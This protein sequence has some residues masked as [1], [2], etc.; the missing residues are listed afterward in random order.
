MSH[1]L[2]YRQKKYKETHGA[3][4]EVLNRQRQLIKLNSKSEL[5]GR[6]A[7]RAKAEFQANHSQSI[8]L[9]KEVFRVSHREL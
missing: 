3:Y 5:F 6:E 4:N 1:V 9:K 8:L 2:V 7:T